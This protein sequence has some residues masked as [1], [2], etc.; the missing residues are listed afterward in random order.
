MKI[1]FFSILTL[2]LVLSTSLNGLAA[3]SQLQQKIRDAFEVDRPYVQ[4]QCVI[5][6]VETRSG[7]SV[8]VHNNG[9]HD[10]LLV[11]EAKEKFLFDIRKLFTNAN[12]FYAAWDLANIKYSKDSK[13]KAPCTS[14]QYFAFLESVVWA[15][16]ATELCPLNDEKLFTECI[17]EFA[18]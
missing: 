10:Y 12:L 3:E 5:N 1:K 11:H 16:G 15:A 7:H 14:T 18:K 4:Y 8:N 6:G 13:S 2:A 9:K 17:S